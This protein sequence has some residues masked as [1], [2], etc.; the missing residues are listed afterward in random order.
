MLW[1]INLMVILITRS[2]A[3]L[4]SIHRYNKSIFILPTTTGEITELVKSC[5]PTDRN[6]IHYG[7]DWILDYKR[8]WN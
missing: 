2:A 3:N 4:E 6:K 8:N 1:Q 5:W 7:I